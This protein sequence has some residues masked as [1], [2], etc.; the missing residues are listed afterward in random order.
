MW[1]LLTVLLTVLPQAAPAPKRRPVDAPQPY[2][3]A[4]RYENP[5][6]AGLR[7][8]ADAGIVVLPLADGRFVALSPDDGSLLWSA[9]FGGEATAPPLVL[10]SAVCVATKRQG[11]DPDG[12]LRALDRATGLVVWSREVAKPIVS[13]LI[14]AEGRI[15]CGSADG[16]VYALRADTGATVWSF[17]TRGPARGQGA[18]LGT[19]VLVGSDDGALYALDRATGAESWRFQTGGPVV[20]RPAVAGRR[21][22][23]TSGDGSTYAID[24]TT[25]RLLWRSRTGAAIEAGPILVDETS[26]LVASFDNFVYLLDARTGDRLW[27]RRM[28]GRLVSDPMPDGRGR[29]IVAP[30][31]DDRLTVISLKDGNKAAAFA[32]DQDEELVGPPT[33]AGRM[34]YLPTDT[35]LLAARAAE[36]Q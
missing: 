8:G 9:D 6:V 31:R 11:T 3:R 36:P 22:L 32:L 21:I 20:G 18:F 4:W 15:Y 1:V 2:A 7:A 34:L 23:V 5:A 26:V 33:A 17:T 13:E 12:V 24:A 10:T 14:E 27:K 29:A 30:L 35:G 19:D 25:R 28:R 16:T